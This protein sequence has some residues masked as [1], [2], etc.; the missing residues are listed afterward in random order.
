VLAERKLSKP[1]AKS[2]DQ[3]CNVQLNARTRNQCNV[4]VPP[5]EGRAKTTNNTS[6][7]W[8]ISTRRGYTVSMWTAHQ[9]VTLVQYHKP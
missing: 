9:Q 5:W 4:P 7:D 6:N 1:A 2:P 3:H 8:D